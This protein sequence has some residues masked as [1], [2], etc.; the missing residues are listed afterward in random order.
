MFHVLEHLPRPVEVLR[1]LR[2]IAEVSTRLVVEVPVLENDPDEEKKLIKDGITVNLN[3]SQSTASYWDY[4][5]VKFLRKG[6]LGTAENVAGFSRGQ[7]G[8][9]KK[10]ERK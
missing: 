1:K 3:R 2:S 6:F 8:S 7:T 10:I 4:F 9:R 5:D